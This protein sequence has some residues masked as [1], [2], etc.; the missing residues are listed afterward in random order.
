[1]CELMNVWAIQFSFENYYFRFDVRKMPIDKT[2]AIL[3][4]P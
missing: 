4:I 1:M 2:N 3:C